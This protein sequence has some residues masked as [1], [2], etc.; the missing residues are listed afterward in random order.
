MLQTIT[1]TRRA[2]SLLG[3]EMIR[4]HVGTGFTKQ[5]FN[6]HKAL[7]CS[8]SSFFTSYFSSNGNSD[9]HES[10][11]GQEDLFFPSDDPR[12][13]ALIVQWLY[14][15]SIS[16]ILPSNVTLLQSNTKTKTSTPPIF[17][18]Q[19]HSLLALITKI[20]KL[21]LGEFFRAPVSEIWPC[22]AEE[23]KQVIRNEIDLRTILTKLSTNKYPT[24]D[25][26]K[27]DF[28]LMYNNAVWFNGDPTH[29][30]ARAAGEI[31]SRVFEKV[32]SFNQQQQIGSQ[33]LPQTPR[34]NNTMEQQQ[35][36][37]TQ[38]EV[39]HTLHKLLCMA[40]KFSFKQ[41]FN[42][43]IT[44]LLHLYKIYSLYPSA[45]TISYV[46]KHTEP[47][48]KF[49]HYIA[50]AVAHMVVSKP[51]CEHGSTGEIWKVL[52]MEGN[53]GLGEEVVGVLRGRN[54]GRVEEAESV[55]VCEVYH[56]HDEGESLPC[57]WAG[58]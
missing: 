57:P 24:L 39:R 6:I 18:F 23:Y 27:A 31:R 11:S 37:D 13:F 21:K 19:V 56:Y 20:S 8:Q 54:G 46:W 12:I 5:T 26:L 35:E 3:E 9:S 48:S 29:I 17:Q 42:A 15:G 45:E 22:Y 2:E 55:G 53:E 32:G 49:R 52:T 40:E 58:V 34:K 14:R 33:P 51:G 41:L 50:R 16:G 43:A 7:L 4:I 1:V 25:G 38:Q 28:D 47:G 44:T 36:R 10:C 30:V